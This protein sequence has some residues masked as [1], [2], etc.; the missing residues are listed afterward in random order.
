MKKLF[1]VC[2]LSSLVA[3][4][5]Q[6]QA[7]NLNDL[8]NL[9]SKT[10]ETVSGSVQ[11]AGNNLSCDD[12]KKTIESLTMERDQY[13]KTYERYVKN[14]QKEIAEKDKEIN[15]L[16]I[17]LSKMNKYKSSA[18]SKDN[19]ISQK[20]KEISEL[21]DKLSKMMAVNNSQI[22]SVKQSQ[23]KQN[24]KNDQNIDTAVNHV[25][26]ETI[27]TKEAKGNQ[28]TGLDEYRAK[29]AE[30]RAK[31]QKESEDKARAARE[32]LDAEFKST[33]EKNSSYAKYEKLLVK[34][35]KN[36]K[37]GM[38][39]KELREVCSD[40]YYNH[41]VSNLHKCFEEPKSVSVK[42][43]DDDEVIKISKFIGSYT[44]VE[45]KKVHNAL[46]KKYNLFSQISDIE[47]Q[48]FNA[49]RTSEVANLYAKGQVKLSITRFSGSSGMVMGIDYYAVP[50]KKDESISL[51]EI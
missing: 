29:K 24:E 35:Y 5:T 17:N 8:S 4:S 45:F 21:K 50:K 3:I 12:E 39:V 51:D 40:S 37:F 32:K 44:Q 47:R 26:S 7:L 11:S 27:K 15:S 46:S 25:E 41:G 28:Q 30:Y 18:S 38:G 49:N 36:I 31:K 34:G 48:D 9:A 6:A 2:V 10:V 16:K 33:Q 22:K 43:S 19:E 23:T 20:N 42:I 14:T 13:K 1:S